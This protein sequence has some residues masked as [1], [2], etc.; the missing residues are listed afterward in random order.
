[1]LMK[2]Q[3]QEEAGNTKVLRLSQPSLFPA[4]NWLYKTNKQQTENLGRWETQ[5]WF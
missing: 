1:M 2:T 3:L 4:V 5:K